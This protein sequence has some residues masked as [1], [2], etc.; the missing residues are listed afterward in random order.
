VLVRGSYADTVPV[1]RVLPLA[2]AG[3]VALLGLVGCAHSTATSAAKPTRIVQLSGTSLTGSHIT[4]PAA[5]D[6]ITVVNLWASWCGP[7]K[8]EAPALVAARK[9]LPADRVD[10]VGLDERDQNPAGRSFAQAR[11]LTYPSI[12]DPLGTLAARMPG[13]PPSSLPVTVVLDRSGAVR[14]QHVGPVTTAQL[15]AAASAA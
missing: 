1:Q 15:V 8:A 12:P 6:R 5:H 14:W 4:V 9:Q 13:V 3:L 10:F 7:C 2:A 11:G